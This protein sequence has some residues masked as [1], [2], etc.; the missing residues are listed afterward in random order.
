V[1]SD[2]PENSLTGNLIDQLKEARKVAREYNQ[3]L[4]ILPDVV[5]KIDPE[6]RFTYLSKSIAILGY[7]E[8]ELI[9]KHFG[10]IVHP[11]DLPNISR[12]IVLPRF[13]GKVTGTDH[14]PKLFDERRA[15]QRMTRKL[16]VR[17]LPKK[18]PLSDKT[19]QY[20]V[21]GEIYATGQYIETRAS[22]QPE[23]EG[24]IGPSRQLN[25]LPKNG[26]VVY[27][28]IANYGKYSSENNSIERIFL[29]TVGVIRD[30]S[31]SKTLEEKQI[32]LDQQILHSKKMEAIGVL[33]G[34]IAH[35]FNN[36]LQGVFGYISMAKLNL[37]QK[38]K[39]VEMIEQAEKALHLSVNL[40]KQ[41]LTFSRGGK[42]LRKKM[43]IL[44]IIE[45]SVKF[46]LSGSRIDYSLETDEALHLVEV[47]EGQIS[48]VI[49]NIIIN[50]DQAMPTCGTVLVTARNVQAPGEGLPDHLPAGRYIRISIKDNGIGIPKHYLPRIFDPYFTTKDKGSGLGLAASYSIVRNHGGMIDVKSETGKGSTF[51]IYLPALDTEEQIIRPAPEA[52]TAVRKGTILLMD[53]EKLIRDI[54]G[55][56]LK[57]LGH[58]VEFALNGEEALDKYQGALSSGRRFDIVI[59]DLTIRGS[60]GGEETIQKLL[61][62]D[63]DVKAI[64]SS[65]Y[66]DSSAISEY[67][68]CGFKACLAKPY[69]VD[70]LRNML[71]GL[72]NDQA[73]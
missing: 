41:L 32:E 30:V 36:L 29:G 13:K 38:G 22:A 20:Q 49:Q 50:A 68:K 44:P 33:A 34:G 61:E 4:D 46:A 37:D 21:T 51:S 11:E 71:D 28:E 7:A 58:R 27:A 35:D 26:K 60:M 48:Q 23:S 3:I 47:D 1:Y 19:D 24:S 40:T 15:R 57:A 69:Q 43:K 17:L 25:H 9:G 67:T 39:C 63:P 12:E 31:D 5:Y 70:T 65:G 64:V 55:V 53:D 14:A 54:A 6:G 52:A 62:I 72:L 18:A 42:P 56:M 45:N 8:D 73:A 59:L 66:A 2:N 16:V 10:T